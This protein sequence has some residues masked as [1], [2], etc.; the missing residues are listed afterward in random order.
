M[1][2]V[3]ASDVIKNHIPQFNP[4]I[5]NGIVSE[6][7]KELEDYLKKIFNE[8]AASFPENFKFLGWRRCTPDEEVR[9]ILE[10]GVASRTVELAESSI[11]LTQLKFS[12]EGQEITQNLYLP[13]VKKGGRIWIRGVAN[14]ILPVLT[15]PV[16]SVE[17]VS[18]Q[19]FMKF[20]T[21]KLM[22][23]QL[24][25]IVR[26]D[27]KDTPIGITYPHGHIHKVDPK[28][29]PHWQSKKDESVKIK[30]IFALYL[31]CEFGFKGALKH[32]A[33][34]DV[35]VFKGEVDWDG[36]DPEEWCVID[37]RGRRPMTVRTKNW[38]PH[39]IKVLIPRDKMTSNMVLG[40]VGGFFYVADSYANYMN[41]IEEF[42]HT[43][44]WQVILGK[45]IFLTRDTQGT[46]V[47]QVRIHLASNRRM[48]D[49]VMLNDMHNSGIYVKTFSDLLA[50]LIDNFG[51]I[52]YEED[53]GSLYGKKLLVLRNALEEII[54]GINTLQF[55]VSG[56][57]DLKLQ[58]VRGE[59]FR[60]LST[61]RILKLRKAGQFCANIL[62]PS[63]N[64]MFNHT[65]KFLM[66][67]NIS[68]NQSDDSINVRDPSNHLHASV[69]EIGS[70]MAVKRGEPT[71]RQLLNPYQK[72][73]V[74]GMTCRNPDLSDKIAYISENIIRE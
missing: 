60:Q 67:N 29:L 12:F 10:T 24:T 35:K 43:D 28:S 15:A 63:D 9:F 54:N 23:R 55:K 11:Y 71:G 6:Q 2:I 72:T 73:G 70:Y 74:S 59:I 25:H 40:I 61:E 1:P 14:T 62:S 66:Q 4:V 30:H 65:C 51:K 5:A 26:I 46:L 52:L 21:S 36:L 41:Y 48:L 68:E 32:Y 38:M 69:L 53:K 22:I 7:F 58:G 39:D 57:S 19:I 47:S 18:R 37:S 45:A 33:D 42:E 64:M 34:C 17:P 13:Y 16:F 3:K 56:K 44:F 8:A 20:L 27:G 31:F 50:Y 49:A